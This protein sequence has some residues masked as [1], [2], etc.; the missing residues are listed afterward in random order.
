MRL[1][2]TN[3]SLVTLPLAQYDDQETVKLLI[4]PMLHETD[5]L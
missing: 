2:N 5:N 3:L 1:L 4:C